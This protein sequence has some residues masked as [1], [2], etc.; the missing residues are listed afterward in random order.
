MS[1]KKP[2]E[3]VVLDNPEEK[4]P[5]RARLDQYPQMLYTQSNLQKLNNSPCIKGTFK[6]AIEGALA[7]VRTINALKGIPQEEILP[8]PN[9]T[10]QHCG[11]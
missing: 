5:V 8:G 2:F 10:H 11:L 3:I 6:A 9:A 1:L 4:D 7:E